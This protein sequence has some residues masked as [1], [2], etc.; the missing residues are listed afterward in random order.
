M[1]PKSVDEF[2]DHSQRVSV[3]M[4]DTSYYDP[5]QFEFLL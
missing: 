2:T 4:V 3:F 1:N 5:A